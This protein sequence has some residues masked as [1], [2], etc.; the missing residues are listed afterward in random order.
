MTTVR[1][2]APVPYTHPYYSSKAGAYLAYAL[3]GDSVR[4]QVIWTLYKRHLL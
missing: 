3:L 2:F 4:N 1:R